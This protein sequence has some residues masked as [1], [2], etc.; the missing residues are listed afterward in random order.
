MRSGFLSVFTLQPSD[1]LVLE[2]FPVFFHRFT[3][4]IDIAIGGLGSFGSGFCSDKRTPLPTN[5]KLHTQ[6]YRLALYHVAEPPFELVFQQC[7]VR[8]PRTSEPPPTL[9]QLTHRL[10]GCELVHCLPPLL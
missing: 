4:A 1:S 10:L 3:F 7:T 8:G 5:L 6:P 2:V 9:L